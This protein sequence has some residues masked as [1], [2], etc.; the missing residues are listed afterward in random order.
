MSG[1]AS[2]VAVLTVAGVTCRTLA[3]VE[4]ETCL[5]RR[6]G[7]FQASLAFVA[8]DPGVAAALGAPAG[9]PVS[10]AFGNDAAT[11]TTLFTGVLDQIGFDLPSGL[12]ELEG[13]D[14]AALLIDQPVAQPFTNQ[15]AAEIVQT[16]A[17][18]AGL[19]CNAVPTG[20][21]SGQ[22]YQIDH[23]RS[24]LGGHAR[25]GTAWELV[26]GLADRENYDVWVANGTVN[27]VPAGSVTGQTVALDV[28]ALA[29][30][31]LGAFGITRL[32]LDRRLALDAG[33]GVTV[34]SWNSR[35]KTA[36]T[37]TA[38]A[39]VA[40][41]ATIT[42][43]MPNE[44][45]Q[46]A[47]ARATALQRDIARHGAAIALDMAGE[48]TLAPR[49]I[50]LLS[51]SAGGAWDGSFLVDLVTRRIDVRRGFEQSVVAHRMTG[52]TV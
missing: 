25:F 28:A 46:T 41:N 6:A 10:I 29:D 18:N 39:G 48:L 43:V 30:G 4:I 24:A 17:G 5:L 12:L 15:T 31:A 7:R 47:L 49:D 50:V 16:V 44:T 9:A 8:D 11:L 33:V 27:F 26:C 2:P 1:S 38:S 21:F 51:N 52:A 32:R 36:I 19:G 37:Q 3:S 20:S 14:D 23:A 34:R 35:Q 45:D 40:D 22:F 13:R 42:F